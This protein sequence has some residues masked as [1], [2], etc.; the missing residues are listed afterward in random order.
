MMDDEELRAKARR[1]TAVIEPFA[2]RVPGEPVAAAFAVFNPSAV[3]PA[4]TFTDRGRE[5]RE[6]VESCTDR[7]CRPVIESLGDDFDDVV[8]MLTPMGRQIRRCTAIQ[9][10]GR[11]RWRAGREAGPRC[12]GSPACLAPYPGSAAQAAPRATREVAVACRTGSSWC[13][14]RTR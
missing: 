8:G 9:P 1:R 6:A 2:G 12:P 13:A 14:R 10:Q 7:Q 3:V 4:V 5:A 11:A